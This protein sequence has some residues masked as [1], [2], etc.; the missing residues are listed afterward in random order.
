MDNVSIP[1]SIK[2]ELE[3]LGLKLSEIIFC[4]YADLTP[5][6][7][8]GSTWVVITKSSL[9]LM[10]GDGS[11]MIRTFSGYPSSK[12]YEP[13]AMNF[14]TDVYKFND[15]SEVF[16]INQTVGGIL[17]VR[18]KSEEEKALCFFS[19]KYTYSIQQCSKICTKLINNEEI[20]EFD[21]KDDDSERYCPKCGAIYPD[22][23][24]K[25]CPNCLDK[26]SV[27]SRFMSFCKPYRAKLI[28]AS[29]CVVLSS[30]ITLITP[31]LNGTVL[32]D[33]I[34]SKNPEMAKFFGPE[35]N[36]AFL[37][38]LCTGA[39]IVS[40]L[41]VQLL[42]LGTN[43][44]IRTMSPSVIRDIKNKVFKSMSKLGLGFY[45]NHQTGSLL[46]RVLNDA[47]EI[48]YFLIDGVP[49][50]F[51]NIFLIIFS[52]VFMLILNW[53]LA[54]FAIISMPVLFFIFQRARR[55]WRVIYS[56]RSKRER[57]LSSIINDNITGA[58]VV[59]AFGSE[60]NETVN[61]E[62]NS[63]RLRSSEIDI[64]KQ[65]AKINIATTLI[66]DIIY[67]GIICIGAILILSGDSLNYGLLVTFTGYVSMLNQPMQYFSNFFNWSSYAMTATQRIFEIIDTQ[68]EIV[69][70]DNAA[71]RDIKGDVEFKNVV[72]GYVK[73]RDV[74]KNVS[75][76]VTNGHM[77]G[78]VGHSGTGKSTI[79][80]L[81][82]RLY[83][84]KSG[85]ILI[86]GINIKDYSIDSLRRSISIV[87]QETYIFIGSV[88]DN[89]RYSRPDAGFDEVVKAAKAAY[90]HDFIMAMP[91][92]YDT[93]IGSSKRQLSGGERQRISIARAILSNSRILILDEATASVDTQTERAIQSSID[94]LIEGRTTIS[95][96]HRLSTLKSADNLIVIEDGR[97][98][99]RGTGTQ[100][101]EQKGV[102]YKLYQLQT[103]S[104][105]MRGLE[106]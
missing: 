66:Y 80:N 83:D 1:K 72:F 18:N 62:K 46:N 84:V 4:C 16:V 5:D 99:E 70:K 3:K 27:I 94:H 77:L 56:I 67:Y 81:L 86:D 105:A 11:V 36:F 38:L 55:A 104:L 14:N 25:I 106:E 10:K 48:S 49:Q 6:A 63:V 73:E 29:V 7:S 78:I 41:I 91:D 74:I 53:K 20:T 89:I 61:F 37:L 60:K 12:A 79:A 68:P 30:I 88:L 44:S 75:F 96:A 50:F 87:S 95:I 92:G 45:T 40:Q 47:Q 69:N 59:K 9:Y 42:A 22:P 28:I 85:E 23:A 32:F 31:Y 13:D 64:R 102:Y 71:E 57:K 90:A 24:R 103:K 54:L 19:S 100:L 21:L 17:C 51:S 76:S 93:I 98:V 15:I 26:R 39:I 2:P 101:L 65:N 97:I 35:P 43:L 58:R 8:F 33:N 82:M 34:L 52:T